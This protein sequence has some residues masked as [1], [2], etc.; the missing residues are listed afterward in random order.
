MITFLSVERGV[1]MTAQL[2]GDHASSVGEAP[3]TVTAVAGDP[4]G[5]PGAGRM[6]EPSMALCSTDFQSCDSPRKQLP[7][8]PAYLG[9]QVFSVCWM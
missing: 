3:W 4:S 6:E 8:A 7:R 9:L 1:P 2:R 5:S